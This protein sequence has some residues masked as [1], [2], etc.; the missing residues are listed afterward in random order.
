MNT[1]LSIFLHFI[2]T[3]DYKTLLLLLVKVKDPNFF[4]VVKDLL[5]SFA[6]FAMLSGYVYEKVTCVYLLLI[7]TLYAAQSV[8]SCFLS[9]T[10]MLVYHCECS[11]VIFK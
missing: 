10:S 7:L 4:L 11:T 2:V 9:F 1:L 8:C 6:L 5:L 3:L